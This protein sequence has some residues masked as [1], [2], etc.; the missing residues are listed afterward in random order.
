MCKKDAEKKEDEFVSDPDPQSVEEALPVSEET[1]PNLR[2]QLADA[3]GFEALDDDPEEYRQGFAIPST[4]EEISDAGKRWGDGSWQMKL[5][6]FINSDFVQK[7]L[8]FLLV[9]D[10]LV[11]FIELG[12]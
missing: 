5:L 8:V 4:K 3:G 11:L 1:E 7:F 2:Q 10:V 12:E 6:T 9:C